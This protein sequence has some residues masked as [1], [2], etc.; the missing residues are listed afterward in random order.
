[1]SE[2][3]RANFR[4]LSRLVVILIAAVVSLAIVHRILATLIPAVFL[5]IM[6]T[7]RYIAERRAA[8]EE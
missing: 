1:M 5:L 2:I 4:A 8:R 7:L 6:A 3:R